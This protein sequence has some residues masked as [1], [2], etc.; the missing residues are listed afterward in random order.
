MN[1]MWTVIRF[2]FMNKARTK[3]FLISTLIF[4]LIITIGINI[5]FLIQMF[6]GDDSKSSDEPTRIGLVYQQEQALAE[7]LETTWNSQPT[8]NYELVKYETADETEL[9]QAIES[10]AIEGYVQFEAQEG[11]AFPAVIYSSENDVI[12]PELQ[13]GLQAALQSLKIRSV[14]EGVELT[15]AQVNELNTPVQI[16]A[17][18]I[19]P[20]DAGADNGPVTEAEAASTVA[21]Y[22]VVYALIILFFFTLMSTGNLIASEVTTEKSSRIMEILITSVSPL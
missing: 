20:S 18:S 10:G 11:A 5:P 17:R 22:I 14:L 8:T 21:N 16:N 2:T 6:M 9:N 12:Q 7:Q 19:D 15:D 4:A 3:S 13:A 1:N